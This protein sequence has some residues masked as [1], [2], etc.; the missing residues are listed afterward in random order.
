MYDVFV[1]RQPIYDAHLDVYGYELLFRSSL[2]NQAVFDDPDE[3]SSQLIRN[4]LLEIGLENVVG[5][6]PAFINLTPGFLTGE[7][8]LPLDGGRVV[9]EIR[10]GVLVEDDLRKCVQRLR[11][12]GY[13]LALDDAALR[14]PQHRTLQSADF[15]KL[16][17][18]LH[19]RQT[20]GTIVRSLRDLPVKLIA[21]RIESLEEFEAAKSL[22]FDLFQGY[23]LSRPRILQGRRIPSSSIAVMQVL[24]SFQKPNVSFG[25][26]EEIISGDVALSFKLLH[27]INSAAFGLRRKVQSVHQA[28]V[29]LGMNRLKN[30][31]TL[32]SLTGMEDQPPAIVRMS[33]FRGKM[34][35]L[36]GRS[37]KRLDPDAFFT[38]GLFSTLDLLLHRP[39]AELLDMLP[40]ADAV[41]SAILDYE[42]AMGEALR[43]T[44]ACEQG[45]LDGAY[46]ISLNK[47]QVNDVYLQALS[48]IDGNGGLA[49]ELMKPHKPTLARV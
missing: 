41:K 7:L 16:D 25:E 43:C 30:L 3:A 42:G 49:E 6:R 5:E 47:P 14:D 29:L 32:I 10:E 37:M 20:L 34:C 44:L 45:D 24:A 48:E 39:L 21:E 36:L 31:L 13:R 40:L 18:R 26:L 33:M 11:D 22:G 38:V 23:F 4:T 12:Q 35:E 1:A 28:L 9:L 27:Y 46:C 2:D 15:V 19:D 8:P 17:F